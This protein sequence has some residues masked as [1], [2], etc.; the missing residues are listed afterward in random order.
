MQN[1]PNYPQLIVL[2][3]LLAACS[4]PTRTVRVSPPTPAACLLPCNPYPAEPPAHSSRLDDWL[5]WGD[6]VTADYDTC[7]R[8]HADCVSALSGT[9]ART[10]PTG[11]PGP[12][13]LQ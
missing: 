10:P 3:I 8:L 2:S 9:P 11:A 12:H 1:W 13:P 5:R 7:R 6:D 4:Q